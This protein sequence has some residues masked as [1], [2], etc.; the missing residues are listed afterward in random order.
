MIDETFIIETF[1]SKEFDY[2]G[3]QTKDHQNISPH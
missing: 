2:Q 1:I 3:A